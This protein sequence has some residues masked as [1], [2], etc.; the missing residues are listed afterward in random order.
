MRWE[1]AKIFRVSSAPAKRAGINTNYR[2]ITNMS[3]IESTINHM[4]FVRERT[5]GLVKSLRELPNV[6]DALGWRP[7]PGRAHMAWQLMHIAITEEIF[8]TQRL[9]PDK[10]GAWSDLWPRFRGGSTPDDDIPSSDMVESILRESREHLLQTLRE[11]TEHDLER[12][13]EALAERN[14]TIRKVLHVLPWHES[15]H[16]GQAHLT[17]NLYKQHVGG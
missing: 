5:L 10:Q 4:E 14:W 16:H 12:V 15:H 9:A 7:G 6:Q 1:S 13:P 17:L 2:E 3:V 11:F 8:A